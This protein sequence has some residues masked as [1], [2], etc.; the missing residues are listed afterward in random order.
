MAENES[1]T[2]DQDESTIIE[3]ELSGQRLQLDADPARLMG[4]EAMLIEDH[5]GTVHDWIGRL[6]TDTPTTRDVLLLGYLGAHRQNPQ[7]EWRYYVRSVAP[8]SMKI[9]RVGGLDLLQATG[10]EP[11]EEKP[12]APPRPRK[13]P[14]KTSG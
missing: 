13:A 5:A 14:A 4:D 2:S 9:L 1:T 10:Q 6:V 7:L 11:A 12:P 8:W 3:F